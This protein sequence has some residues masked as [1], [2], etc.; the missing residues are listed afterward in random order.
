MTAVAPALKSSASSAFVA[1]GGEVRM[2]KQGCLLKE[3]KTGC[4]KPKAADR[5]SWASC[6]SQK[7]KTCSF[8]HTELCIL[9]S[10]SGRTQAGRRLL[11]VSTSKTN[12]LK[13]W[14][15][16]KMLFS[17]Q[18]HCR[19]WLIIKTNRFESD[20]SYRATVKLKKRKKRKKRKPTEPCEVAIKRKEWW[21]N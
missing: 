17:E 7:S 8:F 4:L 19:Q 16:V 1:N 6:S 18:S 15:V 21:R 2:L 20:F 5:I 14:T 3:K 11:L 12:K 13:P 10:I 9:S